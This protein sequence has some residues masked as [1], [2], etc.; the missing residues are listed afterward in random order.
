[1]SSSNKPLTYQDVA[2]SDEDLLEEIKIVNGALHLFLNSKM[3]AAEEIVQRSSRTRLCY[4]IGLALISAIK[5]LATFES[6]DL[7]FAIDRCKDTIVIAQLLRRGDAS[8][9]ETIG[10]LAKGAPSLS[11]VQNMS[12]VQR[13]AELIYAECTLLKVGPPSPHR[14]NFRKLISFPRKAAIS[15]VYSGDFLSVIKEA[16]NFR[17]AYAT[18]RI[19]G[20]FVQVAD[21][22][23][24]GKEDPSI[25]QHLRSGI[26]L[27]N[28]LISKLKHLSA[29]II[30]D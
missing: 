9:F 30:L 5:A 20:K 17:A 8:L 19:L 25:D 7:G 10:R 21:E 28:G 3:V 6:E 13:H 16:L 12:L 27:G 11:S 22:L 24:G 29:V 15:I 23:N 26:H 1:M 18:Y 4:S 14:V 2:L